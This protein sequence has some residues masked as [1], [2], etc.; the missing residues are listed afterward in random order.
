MSSPQGG[1]SDLKATSLPTHLSPSLPS[2][3]SSIQEHP[4]EKREEGE[5]K[6]TIF[7]HSASKAKKPGETS[8]PLTRLHTRK[9]LRKE[10]G[11]K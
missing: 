11:R 5:T 7:S 4:L 9:K 6:T 2:A 3:S 10:G 8:L 1:G